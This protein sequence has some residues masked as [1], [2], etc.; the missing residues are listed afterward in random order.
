MVPLNV[1][2]TSTSMELY[3]IEGQMS[4]ADGHLYVQR[5]WRDDG[6]LRVGLNEH[7]KETCCCLNKG[8]I[9][10]ILGQKARMR[11]D[12]GRVQQ[13]RWLDRPQHAGLDQHKNN[14]YQV[15][16]NC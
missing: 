5:R 12:D 11:Y 6:L 14:V 1:S 8:S 16:M 9:H 4:Y 3:L 10:G 2:V 15:R 7:A 13:Q